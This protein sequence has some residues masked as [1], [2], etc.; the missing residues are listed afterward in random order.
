MTIKLTQLPY[1]EG[2]L[3]PIISKRTVEIHYRG[4]HRTYVDR[5]NALVKVGCG[6]LESII[7]SAW[8]NQDTAVF[9]TAAQV[10]NHDFYWWSLG[11]ENGGRPYG[12]IADLI[13]RDFGSYDSLVEAIRTAAAVFGEIKKQDFSRNEMG[14]Q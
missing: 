7:Q 1:V 12:P 10:W 11:P 5:L 14:Y 3:E 2:A 13:H 4:H 8:S 6:S 9:N